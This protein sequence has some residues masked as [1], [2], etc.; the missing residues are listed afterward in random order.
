MC[1]SHSPDDYTV[2]GYGSQP[3]GGVEYFAVLRCLRHGVEFADSQPPPKDPVSEESS[4]ESLYGDPNQRLPRYIEFM[5]QVEAVV[6]TAGGA[7][8]HDVGCGMGHLL[9]EARRRGWNVQGND[10]IP[11]VKRGIEK[12]GILC[13]IGSL[14]GLAIVPESC[15][16]VTSFCV[17]PHHLT[18]PTPD[19]MAVVRMLRPGGW[20]VCQFPDNGLF[21]RI[22]KA[23]Y[24]VLGD[25]LVSRSIMANL[26]G[27]GGHQFAFTRTNLGQYL[28][29]CGFAQ[30]IFESY[31]AAPKYTLAR[32]GEKPLWYRTAAAIGIYG[33]KIFSDIFGI[34]NH[35]V[36]FAR[37]S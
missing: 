18:E 15:R 31:S 4:L 6:G 13:L 37:K 14:S 3:P 36:V 21:R 8:L 32:F 16:V 2:I 35:S 27:P 10:I 29:V 17:L 22:G 25:S 20:F 11:G 28:A 1:N 9:F 34:P 7:L 19:M 12:N 24:R 30:V 23:L 33:L 5:D 26:Y